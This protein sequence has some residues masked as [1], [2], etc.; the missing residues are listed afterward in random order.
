M[1]YLGNNGAREV[2]FG[3]S[4]GGE[5]GEYSGVGVVKTSNISVIPGAFFL[6]KYHLTD[7][8]I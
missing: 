5:D 3:L 7:Y 6:E 8:N 4:D 1:S 2:E